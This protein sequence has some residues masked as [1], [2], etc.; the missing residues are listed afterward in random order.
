MSTRHHVLVIVVLLAVQTGAC[1]AMARAAP[2]SPA[3]RPRSTAAPAG[4]VALAARFAQPDQTVEYHFMIAVPAMSEGDLESSFRARVVEPLKPV[5]DVGALG[6]SRLCRYVD[7]KDR[8]LWRH[9]LIVRVRDGQITVKARASSP[10]MLLDLQGCASGKYEMDYFGAPDYSISS[11]L[12]FGPGE[13]DMGS[14]RSAPGGLWELVGRKC[15]EL[16]RQI[17]PTVRSSPGLEIPGTAHVYAAAAALKHPGAARLKEASVA[18]WFF[19]P[20]D[21]FLVELAFTGCVKDRA[22][23]DR[24]YADLRARL[25][26]AGLLRADQSSK[27]QQYFSAYFGTGD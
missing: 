11:D 5:A 19:P 14:S 24:M 16:W 4:A 20:T 8:G 26:S 7:S 2:P 1:A 25:R 10:E 27:T 12:A 21:R 13:F 6:R 17:R 3:A 9:H 15:P 22:E 18:V 23:V